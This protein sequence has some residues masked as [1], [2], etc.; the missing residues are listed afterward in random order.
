MHNEQKNVVYIYSDGACSGNPGRG[1][2]G[3]VLRFNG[4][5]KD[6]NG[7]VENTTNNQM[8]LMGAIESLK[9]LKRPS[10]VVLTTDSQ[11]VCKGM[12]E[13]IEGWIKKGW[14]NSSNKPVK[15]MELWKEL[16]EVSQ[17]H[18][19]EWKWIKGHAGFDG[20]EQADRLAV[21]AIK[22]NT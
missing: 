2:W 12:N 5:Q 14:K 1:G 6:I 8:E 9:A 21:Q 20:N 15:N 22:D 19:I 13:W 4:H 16:H 10:A 11:Y 3:A 17:Q 7:Y 18:N